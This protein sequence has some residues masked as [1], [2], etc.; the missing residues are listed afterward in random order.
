MVVV[1]SVLF[2]FLTKDMAKLTRAERL[3]DKL[4]LRNQ[5]GK[6]HCLL[7]PLKILTNQC[8]GLCLDVK[9]VEVEFARVCSN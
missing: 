2:I 4:C 6:S 3:V 7:P 8:W 9:R 5:V 1:P